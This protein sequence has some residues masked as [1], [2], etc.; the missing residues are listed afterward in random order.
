[1]YASLDEAFGG[2]SGNHFLNVP[3]YEKRH[4]IHQK[5]IDEGNLSKTINST[6]LNPARVQ[7]QYNSGETCDQ[8]VDRNRQFNNAVKFSTETPQ[9]RPQY[10]WYPPMQYGYLNY[11]P[12]ISS[13][14]YNQPY[15]YFPQLAH[16]MTQN[17]NYQP[18]PMGTY[19][20]DNY[21][22][23]N[24]YNPQF[25]YPTVPMPVLQGQGQGQQQPFEQR[26]Q[27]HPNIKKNQIEHFSQ[28]YQVTPMQLV[29]VFFMFF[30]ILLAVI[31]CLFF[32]AICQRQA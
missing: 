15:T 19:R 9:L 18:M 23:G 32:L 29:M 13:A 28:K 1:M 16:E 30:L 22:P 17:P 6:S 3:L 14:F 5:R 20:G 8:V 26:R 7:C 4:P 21:M 31:L 11:G 24:Y 10:P 25:M 12:M 2:I 27:Y